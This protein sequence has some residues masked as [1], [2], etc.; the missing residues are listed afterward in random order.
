MKIKRILEINLKFQT[1]S[2]IRIGYAEATTETERMDMDDEEEESSF[3]PMSQDTTSTISLLYCSAEANGQ[4][5]LAP[6]T[7]EESKVEGY[8]SSSKQNLCKNLGRFVISARVF[9]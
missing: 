8:T 9:F 1:F 4:D 7:E 6:P 2:D 3:L 5:V